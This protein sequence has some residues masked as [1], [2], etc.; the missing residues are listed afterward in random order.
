MGGKSK[1]GSSKETRD[2]RYFCEDAKQLLDAFGTAV[3]QLVILHEQQFLAVIAGDATANRFDL[4]IHEASEKKQDA[5][6]A[7]MTHLEQHGC[8]NTR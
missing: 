5:K 1:N 4:L 7:Y 2:S 6:Y 3:Q 8:S